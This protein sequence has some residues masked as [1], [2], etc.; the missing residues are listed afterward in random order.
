MISD[1]SGGFITGKQKLVV[2]IIHKHSRHP[3]GKWE[4]NKMVE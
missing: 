4:K 3:A 2:L 1:V